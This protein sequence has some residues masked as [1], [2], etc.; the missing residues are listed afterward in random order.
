MEF[1][2]KKTIELTDKEL[3]EITALFVEVF[4]KERDVEFSKR[5]YLNNP[6]GTSYHVMMY[7]DGV[8]VGHVAGIPQWYFVNGK[9]VKGLN[10]ID[11][12]I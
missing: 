3:H 5:Q 1:V 11:L 8:L 10:N 7:E 12:M 4:E 2:A 9:K 6:F